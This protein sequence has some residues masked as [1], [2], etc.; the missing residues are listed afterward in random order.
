MKRTV[1][2]Q[3][4]HSVAKLRPKLLP[5]ARIHSHDYRGQHWFVLSDSTSGR[6]HR[7]S[8]D[9]YAIVSK[10]NGR[11]TVEEL[12]DEACE[13]GGDGIPTQDELVKLLM[14]LHSN[15]L[16]YCDVTP[17]SAELFERYRK[18]KWQ[19]W[20]NLVTQPLSIRIPLYNPDDLLSRWAHHFSWLFTPFGA[21][22]WIAVVLPALVLAG[23]HWDELTLNL[24]DQV[25]SADNLLVLV[26]VFPF[27]KA[28][29]ELGHGFAAKVWGGGVHEMGIMFLV[30][31]PIPY[32]DASSAS[33]FR[34]KHRR[35]VVGAAG[36]LA[37]VFLAALAMYVWVLVEPGVVRAI[38]FNVMLIAGISTIIVNG[39]PLLRFD[40]YFILS[41]LI[42]MPNLAQRGQK[43]L[44]YLS[45][46][47]LFGAREL[48]PPNDSR[49]EKTW[50][51]GYTISAWCYRMFI[52]V[53]IILFVAGEFFIFGVILAIV[54]VIG[55]IGKPLWKGWK[56]LLESPTLHRY[57]GRAIVSTVT[58]IVLVT[59]FVTYVPMPLRTLS[60]GVVWLP[61]NALVRAQADGAFQRWLVDPSSKV[62][63][64]DV[65]LVMENPELEAELKVAR[66]RVREVQGRYNV[67]Q[68][69]NPVEA[70]ALRKQ[71]L[72][73]K[74]SL[75]DIEERYGKLVIQSVGSGVL[76]VE[77]PHNMTGRFYRK[78]S[79][80]G[81][82]MDRE[83]L[84]ARVAVSQDDIGLVRSAIQ[85]V[86][87]RFV[88]SVPERH[89]VSVLREVPSGLNELPTL[90]LSPAGGGTIP[91]DPGDSKGL[92]T[93]NRVFFLDVSL[94][95]DALPETFGG[96]VY[97]RFIHGAEPLASQAYRR[98][99]QLLLSRF[100]V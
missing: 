75:R 47:Y 7:I 34:S 30:F 72:Y 59:V 91:V 45:D 22:L 8:P 43:Y 95:K 16:L 29:H 23:Q 64:G 25:L 12:W 2:S 92:K 69:T 27:V 70:D 67:E 37:E 65:L 83:Q 20:K 40:G 78:G 62:D 19:K 5:H 32:V 99:R 71:L 86:E 44:T 97:V 60:E 58:L 9:S 94:P 10:M 42:E 33:T 81:Y 85:S 26:I 90:A 88:D 13:S 36:M 38:A 17:D 14:Q 55:F 49:A 63:K 48:T 31:A 53:T 15:D 82:V 74:E 66:A 87:I 100:S 50:F 18:R 4:W 68:F 93:L 96:R 76:T 11:R 28:A 73:E 54:A 41:D 80:L 79:L 89:R 24:S 51:V 39:N 84:V 61:D 98:V 35:A 46:R 77:R 57:R 21:L 6:N 1:F 56:H 3:S 52:M